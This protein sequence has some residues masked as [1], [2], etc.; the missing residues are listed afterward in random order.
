MQ[1]NNDNMNKNNMKNKPLQGQGMN[2]QFPGGSQGQ[3]MNQQFPGGSQGQ[4]TNQQFPGGSQGQGTN[5]Q[6][7]GGSQGQGMNQQFPGGSQG[8][9]GLPSMPPQPQPNQQ[10]P[11]LK[12]KPQPDDDNERS[13]VKIKSV[14]EDK[15]VVIGRDVFLYAAAESANRGDTFRIIID[16]NKAK[17]REAGGSFVRVDNRDFLIADTDRRGATEFTIYRTGDREYV[18]RAPNGYFVRVRENDNRLVA[19]A[20]SA[21]SRTRF[22]FRR[23][24]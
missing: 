16:G 4:G 20:V 10:Q 13:R 22:R 8:Q 14:F 18:L 17:I 1:L 9:G 2:S 7:P 3:G 23:V 24:D 11:Q 15:F 12:S 21:G 6:F 19:R 5:Q